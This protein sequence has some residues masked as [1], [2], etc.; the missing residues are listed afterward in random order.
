MIFFKIKVPLVAWFILLP[1]VTLSKVCLLMVSRKLNSSLPLMLLF[2]SSM[3]QLPTKIEL[4]LS[5]VT[6][7]CFMS[8]TQWMLWNLLFEDD[9][10]ILDL[11]EDPS[12][13]SVPSFLSSRWMKISNS[14]CC[15]PISSRRSLK[16]GVTP[17]SSFSLWISGRDSCKGGRL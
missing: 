17:S 13:Q 9:H 10:G 5:S 1:Q 2:Y 4:L 16:I 15:K 14:W 7:T 8:S 3:E 6:L 12:F 11:L